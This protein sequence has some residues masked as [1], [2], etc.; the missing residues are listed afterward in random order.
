VKPSTRDRIVEGAARIFA[1]KGISEVV[2]ADVLL[3]SGISRR[4]FYKHFRSAEDVLRAVYES[5]T[6]ELV[7][8]VVCTVR[9]E[10]D[11][12]KKV[13]GAVDAYLKHVVDS[14]ALII[15]L[16]AEAIRLGSALGPRRHE[17]LV[18][19]ESAIDDAVAD[20]L[21]VRV[22]P[23]VY[24]ALLTAVEGLVIHVRGEGAFTEDDRQKVLAIAGPIWLNVLAGVQNLPVA[25]G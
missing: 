21:G 18:A 22:D 20:L 8:V 13:V 15:A 12:L 2:V 24:R 16:H 11:P 5:V 14:G 19:I 10:P 6:A 9:D 1:S 7:D 23:L 25:K 17:T 3:A 4:T